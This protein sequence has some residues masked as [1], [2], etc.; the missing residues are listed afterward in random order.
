MKKNILVGIIIAVAILITVSFTSVVGYT[1]VKSSTGGES[2]LFNIRTHR[3]INTTNERSIT[4]DYL[5]KG[6][7]LNLFTVS[8]SGYYSHLDKVMKIIFNNPVMI[9]E[10][11]EKIS[12]T[13]Q[14]IHLFQKNGINIARIKQTLA[15][16]QDNPELLKNQLNKFNYLV[17]ITDDPQQ[18]GLSTSSVIGC[19]ITVIILL[20]LAI[21]IGVLVAT[22][23]IVTCLNVGGCFGTVVQAILTGMVQ[24][25]KHP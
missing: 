23:T 24:E 14:I 25:L 10:L 3:A 2:P 4:S 8:P 20:P 11:L 1:S 19:F 12:K 16:V 5:G 17:D 18:L 9:Q 6:K 22:I 7:T 13:P 15:Q 21:L